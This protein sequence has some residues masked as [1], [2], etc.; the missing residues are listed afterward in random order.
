MSLFTETYARREM[1]AL[2]IICGVLL[3]SNM[4]HNPVALSSFGKDSLVL[5]HLLRRVMDKYPDTIF[6]MDGLPIHK[7][8]HAFTTAAAMGV[9]L[10]T[11]PPTGYDY[12]QRDDFFDVIHYY[13]VTESAFVTLYT[14]CRQYRKNEKYL[15]AV[16]DLLNYPR[17][18]RYEFKWD[19]IFQ[20]QKQTDDLHIADE[21]KFN[22]P[23]APFDDRLMVYPIYNWTDDDVWGY[24]K[25]FSLMK[26]IQAERYADNPTGRAKTAANDADNPDVAPTCYACLDY[27][28][29]GQSV[30]CP[31]VKERIPFAG[32]GREKADDT[33]R[34]LLQMMSGILTPIE[35]NTDERMAGNTASGG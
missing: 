12:I 33:N 11:Y 31:K 6:L 25:R 14:G 20:G 9:K 35:G 8:L 28:N 15:C 34:N 21:Y 5:L 23:V 17:I 10:F 30:T 18:D 1:E 4:A 26:Y 16:S 2:D 32:K 19:C 27:R 3:R 13:Y 7:Y 22:E 29:E 24:I